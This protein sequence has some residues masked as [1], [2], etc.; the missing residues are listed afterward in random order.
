[1]NLK[2]SNWFKLLPFVYLL[3]GLLIGFLVAYQINKD[4]EIKREKHETG[5]S[6]ISPLLECYSEKSDSPE[7]AQIQKKVEKIIEHQIND[8]NISNASVYFRDLANGPWFGI[9]EEENFTPASLLKVSILISYYKIAE[10]NPEIL[11]QKILAEDDYTPSATQNI[12]PTRKI[13]IGKEYVVED[14]LD[15]MITDSS[16]HATQLLLKL[17]PESQENKTYQD[18]GIKTPNVNQS[19]DYMSVKDYSSFFRVLY[20]ASYLNK[21]YSEKALRL[22]SN[23]KYKKALVAGV[24]E[25]T[26]VAHK[27]GEREVEGLKQ[28]HDCGI[29]YK[30][31]K[32]YLLCV[33]TRGDDFNVLANV[34]KEISKNVYDEVN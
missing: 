13:E 26:V 20:N 22:L 18:L 2:T 14:L 9:N 19:E 23:S 17:L 1:M 12:F 8:K 30:D 16:N 32:T 31:S 11:Q 29:I 7:N 24:P 28:L 33:M 25:N 27:F 21:E 10:N 15:L 3:I 5:Y 34:I 4:R 6:L